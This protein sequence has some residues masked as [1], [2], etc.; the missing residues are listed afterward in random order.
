MP[1]YAY[2][3]RAC[4]AEFEELVRFS[5]PDEEIACPR[6]GQRAAEKRLTAFA[7]LGRESISR[8]ALACGP[9]P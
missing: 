4:G 5:T 1:L 3:C 7:T 2:R 9:I 8:R 6:C